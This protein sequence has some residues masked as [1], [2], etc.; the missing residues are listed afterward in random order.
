M[1]YLISICIFLFC[2]YFSLAQERLKKVEFFGKARTNFLHQG[3][4]VDDDTTNVNKANYGHSLI[5][6]GILVRPSNAT[7]IIADLRIR[8]EHGGF[9][10]GAV[11][12]GI[13]RLTFKG[14][15]ND[16]VR[17]KIGDIDLKMTPYTLYNNGYQTQ[18][19][20]ATIFGD[21]RGLVSYEN[22][23][24]EN[25]WRQQGGQ[26]EFSFTYPNTFLQAINVSAFTTRHKIADAASSTPERLFS[27][28]SLNPITSI[29][30]F[31]IHTVYL[32]DLQNTIDDIELFSTR[33]HTISG[34]LNK[35]LFESYKVSFE[36]GF[37]NTKIQNV[38]ADA[39]DLLEDYFW[40]VSLSTEKFWGIK[41]AL[42][43]L[44]NGAYYRAPG[45]QNIRLNYTSQSGVFNLIGNE[46]LQR[47]TGLLDYLYNDVNYYNQFD[48]ALDVYNPL[49]NNAMPYG[50]ATPNRKGLQLGVNKKDLL[51]GL[52]VDFSGQFY[53][54]IVGTGTSQLKAF[55]V[56]QSSL[57]YKH[58]RFAV[59]L[60][61]KHENTSREGAIYETIDLWS[62]QIDGGLDVKLVD[63]L[64]FVS[65][66][67]FQ[68]SSGN[69][70]L[71]SYDRFNNP[72]FFND[73]EYKQ[74]QMLSAIGLRFL[75]GS[76]ST[77]TTSY[78]IFSYEN[79]L[80]EYTINQFHILYKLNF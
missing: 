25:Y 13:R 59:K 31:G 60:G 43:A 19:N 40:N 35:G 29:G 23:F 3:L 7:E 50:Q 30:N 46:Q 26:I 62:R 68:Q 63:N 73:T 72:N 79:E 71:V 69:E 61:L 39:D 8:N 52:T 67:K 55:K 27:G 11:S 77:L 51:D 20:E 1:K 57:N 33:A 2:S 9:F 47:P 6:L 37:S 49:F 38:V 58:K 17:Y 14:I 36:S 15:I 75:F 22:Y 12:F 65:G 24:T 21:V 42:N 76:H 74:K 45:A 64:E 4:S 16:A 80:T 78:H 53:S 10:G 5:D 44:N 48:E 34:T 66:V 28:V 41:V 56:Y 70:F 18:V 54:E 32:Y